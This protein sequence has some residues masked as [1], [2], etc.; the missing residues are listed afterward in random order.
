VHRL[1]PTLVRLLRKLE[2]EALSNLAGFRDEKDMYE[3]RGTLRQTQKL[4]ET[5]TTL[6]E[7]NGPRTGPNLRSAD[8]LERDSANSAGPAY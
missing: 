4:I 6:N 1:F 7:P 8:Q 3:R 2:S 5:L